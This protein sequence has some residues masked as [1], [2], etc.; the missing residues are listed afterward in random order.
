MLFK[1]KNRNELAMKGDWE[2]QALLL[3][4]QFSQL[5]HED[6]Q[7]EPGQEEDLLR[8]LQNRLNMHREEVIGLIQK[9]QPGNS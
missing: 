3:Q 1:N 8:R 5:R 9:G 4:K 2:K 7:F 6:L